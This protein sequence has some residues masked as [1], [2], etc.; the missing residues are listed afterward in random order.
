[1]MLNCN[2]LDYRQVPL[3][4]GENAIVLANTNQ[5]R[6]LNDSAYNDRVSE[7]ARALNYVQHSIDVKALGA[8]TVTDLSSA[9]PHFNE[10]HI[11]FKRA[12][13]VTT[14]NARVLAAVNALE[15]HDFIK[16]GQ[17]MQK[18]HASLRDDF[19]VSSK[20]LDTLVSL[21]LELDGVLGARLTGAGFGGCTVNL[22]HQSSVEPFQKRVGEAYQKATGLTAD[23]YS[24]KPSNGV[25]EFQS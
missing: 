13:H 15:N 11:A 8:L 18:S 19:E 14:E 2:S 24:I 23:F 21:A 10:D 25:Q 3:E 5:R 1:M 12:R 9:K 16:F 22:M 7:C 17:L 6:E 20:A 4:L